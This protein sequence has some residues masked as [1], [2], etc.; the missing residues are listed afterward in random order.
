M[1]LDLY[2]VTLSDPSPTNP[3]GVVTPSLIT[4]LAN[5]DNSSS[6]TGSLADFYKEIIY[7]T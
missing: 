4:N 6:I 3:D 5:I 1:Q 7:K 2:D